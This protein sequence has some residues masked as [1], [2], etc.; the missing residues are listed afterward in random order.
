M[1][2][3]DPVACG[4]CGRCGMAMYVESGHV[5]YVVIENRQVSTT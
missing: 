3:L 4:L 1:Q 2:R 5:L